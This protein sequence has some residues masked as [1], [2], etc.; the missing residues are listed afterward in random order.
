[1]KIPNGK[2]KR[3]GKYFKYLRSG[4]PIF[5]I[6]IPALLATAC[7]HFNTR[8]TGIEPQAKSFT[9]KKY[10]VLGE[11]EGQSSSFNLLWVIPVT[12][13]IDY[14]KAVNQAVQS[15]RGD[16]LIDVRTWKERQVWILGYIE[17]LYVKGKV[18]RYE[19]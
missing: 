9:A 4:G 6:L 8:V 10:E 11:A 16:N 18:I 19:R 3:P 17:I 15:K 14:D 12:P 13:R 5:C 2:S 1:M 7:L